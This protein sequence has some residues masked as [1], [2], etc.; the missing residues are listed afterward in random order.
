MPKV[1]MTDEEKSVRS[2]K[3]KEAK[4]LIKYWSEILEGCRSVVDPD[5]YGTGFGRHV[6]EQVSIAGAMIFQAK[7]LLMMNGGRL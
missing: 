2:S 7:Q 3:R 6:R 4:R 5:Q 1:K